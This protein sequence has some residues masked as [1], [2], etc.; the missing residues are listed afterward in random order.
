MMSAEE[1]AQRIIRG[2]SRRKRL[3]L[4]EFDGRATSFIGKFA[5]GLLD[6]LFYS[7]MAK[8]PDSPFK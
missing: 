5:P 2:L 4:M 6:K 8:E 7:H 3:V 1:V